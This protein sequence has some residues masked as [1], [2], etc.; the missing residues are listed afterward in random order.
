MKEEDLAEAIVK[1]VESKSHGTLLDGKVDYIDDPE[2]NRY[3]KRV[4][5][6]SNVNAEL[7][8]MKTNHDIKPHVNLSKN[9]QEYLE[10]GDSLFFFYKS[11]VVR[12]PRPIEAETKSFTVKI[13]E[14]EVEGE[15]FNQKQVPDHKGYFSIDGE[16]NLFI[17]VKDRSPV[18]VVYLG[19]PGPELGVNTIC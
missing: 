10:C 4:K 13:T 17:R 5:I 3:N 16:G 19:N 7:G 8:G 2:N 18:T 15:V 12:W 1:H 6:Q 11:T 14:E 9:G